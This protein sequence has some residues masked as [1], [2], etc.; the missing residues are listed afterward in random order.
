[1]ISIPLVR[2]SV[3]GRP[4]PGVA[5]TLSKVYL[6]ESLGALF[7]GA[8][9][10]LYGRSGCREYGKRGRTAVTLLAEPVLQAE[11][12][13]QSG[14]RAVYGEVRA[15]AGLTDASFHEMIVDLF[16]GVL[17]TGRLDDV[18]IFPT[19]RLLDLASRLTNREF[20]QDA[21]ARRDAKDVADIVDKLRVGVSSQDN[22]ISDHCRNL[23][24]GPRLTVQR[25][26]LGVERM[27]RLAACQRASKRLGRRALEV[28]PTSEDGENTQKNAED[29]RLD[30]EIGRERPTA[31]E[32]RAHSGQPLAGGG[33]QSSKMARL[34]NSRQYD[35]LL[36]RDHGGLLGEWKRGRSGY[37]MDE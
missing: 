3:L 15:K 2:P 4:G 18:D 14:Q 32:T 31:G 11:I 13:R 30:A 10:L 21:I 9:A 28:P 12:T 26:E 17:C 29:T 23:C 34:K 25:P 36:Q 6:P 7:K 37:G 1:M 22:E 35:R 5:G 19:H 24:R 33:M 27:A 20:G 8:P 16:A